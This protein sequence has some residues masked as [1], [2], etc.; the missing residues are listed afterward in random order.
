MFGKE[1]CCVH[2]LQPPAAVKVPLKPFTARRSTFVEVAYKFIELVFQVT[3]VADVGKVIK[4][5]NGI[6]II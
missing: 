6:E 1:C 3:N 4:I 2:A 5:L